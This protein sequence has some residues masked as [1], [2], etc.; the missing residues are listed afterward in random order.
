MAGKEKSNKS[1]FFFSGS[2]EYKPMSVE[3]ES[4]EEAYKIYEKMRI[5][6]N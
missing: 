2:L 4:Q 5:K 1:S 3:A 6:I